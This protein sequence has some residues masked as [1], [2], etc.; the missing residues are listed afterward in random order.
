MGIK[1]AISGHLLPGT[2]VTTILKKF[3]SLVPPIL[4]V[5]SDGGPDHKLTYISVQI[6]LIVL[7]R[8]HDLDYICVARTAPVTLGVTLRNA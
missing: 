7:F 6:S 8:H 5:Y 2:E 1:D 4:F 3:Y